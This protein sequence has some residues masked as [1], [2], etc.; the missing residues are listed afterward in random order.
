MEKKSSWV[1]T[2][3]KIT[4]TRGVGFGLTDLM[5]GGWNNIVSGVI[6]VFVMSQGISPAL[7]GAITGIGRI[8]DALFS[9]FFGAITDGFY[10]T[11]LGRKFGRRHFF[12]LLGG[13]LFMVAFP[14][15]WVRATNW[16]Y[17]LIV[18]IAI[19]LIIAMILIPWETL[20]TEMTTDYS[21]RTVLSGSRMFISATGTA[22]VFLVLAALKHTNNPN[23]YLITGII[24]TII[25]VL[26][27]FISY[28]STWERPLTAEFIK[29]LE[30]RPKLTISEFMIKTV[31]DYF[32]TFR[33]K[34]FRKHLAIYLLSFT[35]KD[36]YSTLLPTFIVCTFQGVSGDLPWTLQALSVFGILSTLVAAKLMITHGPR[37]LYSLSYIMILVTMIGYAL[38]W[39]LN[40]K[41]PVMI[42]VIISIFYQ[43]AR[44]ILE[45]TPW[46][47]FPFIPDV[48]RIM[49]RGDRA[50]IY[51]AVMTFFRKSTGAVAS[52]IAGILL[53]EIGFN[54]KTMLVFGSTP[55]G[56]QAGITAIFFV[57]PII[58]I[59]WA[60]ILATKFKLNKQTHAVLKDE[61]ERLENGGSKNDVTPET[62]AVVEDLTGHPYEKLWPNEP[63]I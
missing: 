24:W 25:F 55:H 47:V 45:F 54:S 60:L 17:Y 4:V 61:I 59:L 53:A 13:I 40:I 32:S 2:P 33:N 8:F 44:G 5:G 50:G 7:A 19:E 23:A 31:K 21:L 18:Y 14:L 22:I 58:L 46:N 26:A 3:K 10:R 37:F 20:P 30:S 16:I 27:I 12:I 9:L 6:F 38:T 42:L 52:W 62:K 56:I 41:N 48:D 1:Y 39:I 29:E 43:L 36:F 51:A 34:A 15:F 57:G 28:R 63:E 11:K 35:G 49:T